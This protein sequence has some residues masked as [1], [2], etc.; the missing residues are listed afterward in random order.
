MS[1][2]IAPADLNTHATTL[3]NCAAS[4]STLVA[5]AAAVLTCSGCA[6][7]ATADL[8]VTYTDGSEQAVQEI[9]LT[10]L[11]CK[12][13]SVIRVISS[14]S[15]TSDGDEVFLATAPT[16]GRDTYTVSLWFDGFRFISTEKFEAAGSTIAFNDYPGFITESPDGHQP[17]SEVTKAALNGTIACG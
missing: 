16:D 11:A 7:T 14:E 1:I 15:V 9:A 12:T 17:A 4:T 5:L 10:D 8:T 6:P 2:A 3:R 13:S